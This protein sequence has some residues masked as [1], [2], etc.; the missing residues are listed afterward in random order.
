MKSLEW[1]TAFCFDFDLDGLVKITSLQT[2]RTC[3][4][5]SDAWK[6]EARRSEARRGEV[7]RGKALEYG[8][9]GGRSVGED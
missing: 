6:G 2:K 3:R 4:A 7:R 5:D 8:D 1:C 9:D